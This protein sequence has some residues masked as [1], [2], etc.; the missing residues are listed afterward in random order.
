MAKKSPV[1]CV[2]CGSSFGADPRHAEAAKRL[3]VLIA[4]RGYSLVFGGGGP[5]LMGVVARAVRDGGAH[6]LGVLPDFLRAVEK[7]PEW[8]QELI[9]TPDL[10]LRKTRMLA[11][12]DA[13]VVLPGGPGTMDEFF[14]VVT[15]AQLRVLAKPI[16]LVNVAG[17][18][19]PL[20]ALMQHLVTQGFAR[21]QML[22]LYTTVDTPEAAIETVTKKLDLGALQ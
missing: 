19:E 4:E 8:E 9:I 2:F 3:G 16:V 1:V 15:S 13:F 21:P 22:E 10:Q 12:A 6:V 20:T 7:P 18:F 14:E 17:F 11:L 5:G